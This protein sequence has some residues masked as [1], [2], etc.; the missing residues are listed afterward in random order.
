M[1]LILFWILG[2][3]LIWISF[4]TISSGC[5]YFRY[6]PVSL[7][8]SVFMSFILVLAGGLCWIWV[9]IRAKRK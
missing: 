5:L 6:S 4:W 2:S 8:M 3:A 7:F 1:R 9:S